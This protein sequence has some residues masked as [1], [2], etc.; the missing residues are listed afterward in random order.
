MTLDIHELCASCGLA[1]IMVN[2]DI[3]CSW[4]ITNAVKRFSTAYKTSLGRAHARNRELEEMRLV[5]LGSASH[6]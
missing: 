4:C 1:L 3:W 2:M 5:V 6:R